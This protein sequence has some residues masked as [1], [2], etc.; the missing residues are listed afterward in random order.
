VKWEKMWL[1]MVIYLI[2]IA[3]LGGG[4]KV[5][6]AHKAVARFGSRGSGEGLSWMPQM[7]LYDVQTQIRNDKN[8][9]VGC[10]CG[11]AVAMQ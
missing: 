5:R 11:V 4:G 7:N 6:C 3:M 1:G 8:G 10:N 9:A 2:T